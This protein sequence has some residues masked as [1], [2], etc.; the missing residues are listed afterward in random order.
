MSG[1][2]ACARLARLRPRPFVVLVSSTADPALPE[3]AT[4]HGAVGFLP[5]HALRPRTLREQWE[6]RY[7]D[8]SES[9][10]SAM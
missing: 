5:K 8:D 2:E 10:S 7:S 3:L 9:E 6:R 1:L 4:E